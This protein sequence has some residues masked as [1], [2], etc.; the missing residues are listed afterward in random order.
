MCL[1]YELLLNIIKKFYSLNNA[2]RQIMGHIMNM[3]QEYIE[4]VD[5][6]NF[7]TAVMLEHDYSGRDSLR[8]CVELELLELI[9]APKIEAIIKRIHNSNYMQDGDLY[10][11][12]TTYQIMFGN[13]L[14]IADVERDFRFDKK[15]DIALVPQSMWQFG[16]FKDSLNARILGVGVTLIS[17]LLFTCIFFQ[18]VIDNVTTKK[19]YMLQLKEYHHELVHSAND[20]HIEIMLAASDEIF[21]VL[22]DSAATLYNAF[23]IVKILC[24][25]NL[26]FFF[27]DVVTGIITKRLGRFFEF[28]TIQHFSDLILFVTSIWV[29]Q[30]IVTEIDQNVNADKTASDTKKSMIIMANFERNIDYPFQYLFSVI[31]ICLIYRVSTLLQFSE[32]IGPLYKII[33]KMTKDFGSFVILYVIICLGFALVGNINFVSESNQFETFMEAILT[34]VNA[35]LGNF[36]FT[37]M[38]VD[39]SKGGGEEDAHS[40]GKANV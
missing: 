21:E 23:G 9:Q 13:K 18:I 15:R 2:C 11:M 19:P 16:I 29:F 3:A 34:V 6:E 28:P 25:L 31:V 12:S 30:W 37:L 4:S 7:L 22:G 14:Q 10:E 32:E 24:I 35:S 17:F 27:Q 1:L 36:E 38:H 20:T 26:S 40:E 39:Q 33:G 5:E 8:I